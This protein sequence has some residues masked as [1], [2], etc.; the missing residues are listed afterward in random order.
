MAYTVHQAKTHF[1]RLLK[2]AEAGQEVV[3]M[4]GKK[5]IAKI[6][7]INEASAEKPG[8]NFRLIGAYAGQI[9]WDED[10][11]DPMTDQELT[12]SGLGYM[13]DAPLVAPLVAP[14]APPPD[15]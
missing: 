12:E 2:E 15:K 11:F 9:S 13:L 6:V 14:P 3:V 10:A 7:P 5:P 1:S 4:R 8:P